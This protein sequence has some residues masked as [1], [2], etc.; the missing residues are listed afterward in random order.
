MEGS[1]KVT[2]RDNMWDEKTVQRI[3]QLRQ[4]RWAILHM[5]DANAMASNTI[6]TEATY[7]QY[8]NRLKEITKELF[9][10]TKNPIYRER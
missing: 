1:D 5:Y 3:S 9:E 2:Y 7:R 8:D 4:E 6:L 10:L